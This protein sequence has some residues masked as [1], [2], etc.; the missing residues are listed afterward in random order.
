[1]QAMHK[2][3]EDYETGEKWKSQGRTIE[4]ADIIQFACHTGDFHPMT[5]D[6]EF[7]KSTGFKGRFAAGAM[8]FSITLGLIYDSNLES[9]TYGHE[10]LRYP[11]PVYPGDTITATAEVVEKREYPK[12]PENRGIVVIKYET[13]NQSG[14]TVF[15]CT[16]TCLVNKRAGNTRYLKEDAAT[17]MQ[18][19]PT[20]T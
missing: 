1:M 14:Q 17:E 20:V 2:F 13:L 19:V 16:H 8:T 4:L 6:E 5:V 10:R 9:F 15:V 3:F 7:A 12:D 11:N 18:G